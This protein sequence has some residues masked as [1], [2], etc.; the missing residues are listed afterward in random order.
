MPFIPSIFLLYRFQNLLRILLLITMLH[1]TTICILGSQQNFIFKLST[2]VHALCYYMQLF[3]F[4]FFLC[5]FFPYVVEWSHGAIWLTFLDQMVIL[6]SPNLSLLALTFWLFSFQYSGPHFVHL[7]W[8]SYDFLY[9]LLFLYCRW[10]SYKI[11][12]KELGFPVKMVE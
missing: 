8:N 4:F 1:Y 9:G 10:P 2:T 3:S 5:H 12:S 7:W 6:A 11:K